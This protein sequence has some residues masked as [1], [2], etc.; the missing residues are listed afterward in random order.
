M[1]IVYGG[2]G[3]IR[4]PSRFHL[5]ASRYGRQ[6]AA[7]ARSHPVHNATLRV[8]SV[9][10]LAEP[11]LTE[12]ERRMAERVGFV[13]LRASRYGGQV[14]AT[15]RSHPVHNAILRVSSVRWLAEPKLT[16]GERRLAERVG[17]EP[18]CPCGQDAFEAPPLRPLR[19]LS[20]IAAVAILDYTTQV[21]G[22]TLKTVC[23]VVVRTSR[24][25]GI[26]LETAVWRPVIGRDEAPHSDVWFEMEAPDSPGRSPGA[27]RIATLGRQPR[28][29]SCSPKGGSASCPTR[30][31]SRSG[32]PQRCRPDS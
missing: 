9:R 28:G 31:G 2:E 27:S 20:V 16:E 4:P 17:F 25:P 3:G 21:P 22:P 8:S 30:A 32:R 14:A 15:A 11:K 18:T 19:Y 24:Q 13:H 26:L 29:R 6:V 10:W 5:R 1:S 7:T 12:G 23:A